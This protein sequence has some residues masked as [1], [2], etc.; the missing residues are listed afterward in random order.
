MRAEP[1]TPRV[2]A[3]AEFYLNGYFKRNWTALSSKWNYAMH[4][5]NRPARVPEDANAHF[6][7]KHKPWW[8]LCREPASD[9]GHTWAAMDTYT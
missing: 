2:R 9:T 5:D 3:S 1:L 6:V 7:G 8:N 4:Y